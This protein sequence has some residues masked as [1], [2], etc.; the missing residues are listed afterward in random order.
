MPPIHPDWLALSD[1]STAI[2]FRVAAKVIKAARLAI[3][4][5]DNKI[6]ALVDPLRPGACWNICAS[7]IAH[8]LVH[9]QMS[10]QVASEPQYTLV[11]N[12]L[13]RRDTRRNRTPSSWTSREQGRFAVL[14]HAECE[15]A[16]VG[17]RCGLHTRAVTNCN[18]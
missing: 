4:P 16:R 10:S 9:N 1:Q 11:G 3:K 8:L 17:S 5:N 13:R 14:D 2:S 18:R 6:V 12:G 15:K 7:A